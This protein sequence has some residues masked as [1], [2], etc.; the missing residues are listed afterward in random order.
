MS[1]FS[2]KETRTQSQKWLAQ[3]HKDSEGQIGIL[4]LAFQKIKFI[5]LG[6]IL[7]FYTGVAFNIMYLCS[8]TKD[9]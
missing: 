2:D 1:P 9:F 6:V 4:T 5:L 7:Y 3:G 8:Q